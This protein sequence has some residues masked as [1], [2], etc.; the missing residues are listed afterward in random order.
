[1]QEL[2]NA[3][4]ADTRGKTVYDQWQVTAIIA[5]DLFEMP[6]GTVG[7]AL[8]VEYRDFS[9]DD[10]PDELAQTGNSWGL[11]SATE[12]TGSNSVAEIFAEAEVPL[13]AG[14]PG[15][16]SLTLNGSAR[17][18]DYDAG[19]SD[20]VWKLGLN[21]QVVPSVRVRAT[22]GTS[23]RA[24]ALFEQFLGDQTAFAGQTAVDPCI[25]WGESTNE[26]IRRNCA[27]V[28]IPDDYNGVGSSALIISGGGVDN[29]EA[30]TSDA[31]TAGI[32]WTPEFT[33]LNI[34]IDYFKIEVNNQIAQL[35]GAAIASGCY[36]SENFPNAFCDLLTR[37]GPND[38][39][40]ANQIE[41][42][43]DS[44]VNINSQTVEGIDLN[45]TWAGNYDW[46]NLN[47]EA[48][49]TMQFENVFQLFDPD[50]VAGFDDVD[51]VGDIGTPEHVTNLR[52]TAQK[53][54]WSV[55]YRLQYVSETDASRTLN[56]EVNYFGQPGFRDYTA[57]AVLYH[58]FSI[59]YQ[60][61]KWDALLGVNNLLD[62]E[63]DLVSDS[64][65]AVRGNSPINA[66]QYDL[67]GRRIFAR[68][69]FRF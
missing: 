56:E 6:A 4:G 52:A 50:A 26:N 36:G 3:V 8:G 63:P 7:T 66:S 13:L 44:F 55:T 54:D 16:E 25:L 42:I 67:L 48:Q 53:D 69:N 33:N 38:A 15:I 23:Y 12:T 1:M 47:L 39:V 14:I 18:F 65:A 58:N 11:T 9:I 64:A 59:F 27:S 28:G 17:Y 37:I 57:E 22:A 24:P 30:E 2:I 41:T 62:E 40:R 10:V 21:W 49:H 5:G 35:G 20:T 61:D 32:V 60:Q 46:G 43:N 31:F 51:V 68:L 45:A 29:L 34:A 19:G